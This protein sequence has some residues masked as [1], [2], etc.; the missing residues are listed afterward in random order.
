MLFPFSK[1]LSLASKYFFLLNSTI[2]T[3]GV[4]GG[5]GAHVTEE[6]RAHWTN[7]KKCEAER[8]EVLHFR[9][10]LGCGQEWLQVDKTAG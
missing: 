7:L 4:D 3:D 10:N 8:R 5:C 1:V 9:Y 2:L 6:G